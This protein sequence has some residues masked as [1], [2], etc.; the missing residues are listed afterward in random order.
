MSILASYKYISKL[1]V[2]GFVHSIQ[3]DLVQ[4]LDSSVLLW[5]TLTNQ[6]T[7]S[8]KANAVVFCCVTFGD[9]V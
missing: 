3:I 6:S 1:V 2:I 4:L 5:I 9:H 8:V 7:S